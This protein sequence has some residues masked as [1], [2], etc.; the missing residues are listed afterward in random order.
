MMMVNARLDFAD[1]AH[2]HRI[3]IRFAQKM[4]QH[5]SPSAMKSARTTNGHRD[6][7]GAK[8]IF[9]IG[10]PSFLDERWRKE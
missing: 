10:M 6:R 3:S 2:K 1:E 4:M 5:A 8:A 9:R 7:Q